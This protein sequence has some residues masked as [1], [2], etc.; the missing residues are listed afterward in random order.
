[1]ILFFAVAFALFYMYSWEKQDN[2]VTQLSS[3]SIVEGETC[4]AQNVKQ[5]QLNTAQPVIDPLG[6]TLS[7]L[8]KQYMNALIKPTMTTYREG[9]HGASW[10]SVWIQLMFWAIFDGLLGFLVTIITPANATTVTS[11]AQFGPVMRTVLSLSTTLGLIVLVPA[12]FFIFMGMM[13]AIARAFGG[14]GTFLGQCH[15]SM[16]YL[17]PVGLGSKLLS[18]VPVVGKVLTYVLSLYGIGLQVVAVMAAHNLSKG[19]ATAVV[20]VSLAVPLVLVGVPVLLIYLI[21]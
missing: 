7:Q 17:V 13:F 2:Y 12:F 4:M 19:K 3:E 10:A 1:M 5:E 6:Q 14:T 8:P 15:V 11:S 20:A 16:L 21:K 9:L 18:F